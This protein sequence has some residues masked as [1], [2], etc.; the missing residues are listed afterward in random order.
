MWKAPERVDLHEFTDV[1]EFHES[2]ADVYSMGII[3]SELYSLQP[4][5][6]YQD[7]DKESLDIVRAALLRGMRPNLTIDSKA[8][9]GFYHLITRCWRHDPSH[10]PRA[11]CVLRRL[12]EI[13]ECHRYGHDLREKHCRKLRTHL[14]LRKRIGGAAS[15]RK[16]LHTPRSKRSNADMLMELVSFATTTNEMS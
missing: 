15:R 5:W 7:Q 12:R 8:P 4:P 9:H 13:S 1:D 11:S 3:L 16:M 10:R 6:L 14:D 2:A